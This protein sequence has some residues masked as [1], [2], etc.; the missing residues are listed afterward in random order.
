MAKGSFLFKLGVLATVVVLALGGYFYFQ[1]QSQSSELESLQSQLETI[2]N[3]DLLAQNEGLLE[4][5][6][7]KRTLDSLSESVITWSRLI[8]DVESTLPKVNGNEVVEIVSYSG[9]DNGSVTLNVKTVEGSRDP[10]LDVSL[11]IGA[12]YKNASFQNVF[13][14][15]ISGGQSDEGQEILSF[16]LNLRYQPTNN[17]R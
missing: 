1:T 17:K 11:L 5:V 13:V 9:N 7:A 8:S 16:L 10:Y 3:D 2:K 12:F 6:N 15:S 4:A 14:P